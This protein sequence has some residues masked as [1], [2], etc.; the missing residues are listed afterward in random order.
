VVEGDEKE[1]CAWGYNWDFLSLGD[2]NT[3]TWFSGWGMEARLMTML[4]KRIVVA[5]SKEVK[6]G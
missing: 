5:K 6:A 2:I 4:L 3:A 1:P